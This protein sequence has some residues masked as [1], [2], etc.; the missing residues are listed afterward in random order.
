M[1]RI[2]IKDLSLRCIIGVSAEERREKV[3]VVINIMLLV[4]LHQA[5]KSDLMDDT[6]NYRDLKKRIILMVEHSQ[7]SLIEALAERVASLCLE[8]F[9]VQ[10]AQVLVEKP[11]ALRFARSVGVEI[12]RKK[13]D[14]RAVK[15]FIGIG[16]NLDPQK[17]ILK[18][19]EHLKKYF[20]I[21]SASIFYE[22]Q[23][24]GNSQDPH[25]INGVIEIETT[26]SP[27]NLKNSILRPIE[28]LLGRIRTNDKNAPRTIDLDIL[29]YGD[30]V[31]KLDDMTIPDPQIRERDFL[32]F[33]LAELAP[34][35]ILPGWKRNL[36]DYVGTLKHKEMKP[37]KDFSELVKQNIVTGHISPL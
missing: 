13:E 11:G 23:A 8:A 17:N 15:T 9:K 22:T 37:L 18:S 28:L 20:S 3:D 34:S 10:E 24:I 33:S 12:I 35:F 30:Q 6:V 14:V 36:S 2:L 26:V 32:A 31:I 7:Y 1:D 4:D 16:S 5:G 29:V 21:N 19:I 25:F 27:L